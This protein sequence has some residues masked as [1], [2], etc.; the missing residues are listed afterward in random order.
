MKAFPAELFL[1]WEKLSAKTGIHSIIE[2]MRK[3]LNRVHR[4][5]VLTTISDVIG[6]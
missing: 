1:L 6:M 3:Y 2:C 4:K 5:Q